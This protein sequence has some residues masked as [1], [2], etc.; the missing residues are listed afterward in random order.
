MKKILPKIALF[1]CLL[2]SAAVANAAVP[3]GSLLDG[4]KPGPDGKIDVLMVSPHPDDESIYAA[5][6]LILMKQNPAVRVHIL[7]LTTGD[8]SPS[9][10]RL[11]ISKEEMGRVRVEEMKKAATVI[12][13]DSL[14][15]F[16]YHDQGLSSADQQELARRVGQVI[17][18]TG[19]E[20]IISYGPDGITHHPDHVAASRVVTSEFKKSAAQRLYYISLPEPVYPVYY[21]YKRV[22]PLRATVR[23]DIRQARKLKM[24]ALDSH[25][26][27]KYFD[28]PG[29]RLEMSDLF[30][31]EYF[32][33]AAEN[34]APF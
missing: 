10:K 9:E 12:G 28:Q 7:C 16:D 2:F 13:A 4:V 30:R 26:S 31:H 21:L 29:L 33:L 8:L 14:T 3:N 5:G 6:T 18:S 25:S 1:L 15:Q 17:K 20:V 22:H 32:A 34:P 24:L 19:A 27:Q 11:K 23:V